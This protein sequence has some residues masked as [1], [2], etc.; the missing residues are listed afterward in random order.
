MAKKKTFPALFGLF[1]DGLLPEK[2]SIVGYARSKMTDDEFSKQ[3]SQA[4]KPKPKE[5]KFEETLK[6]FV[7]LCSYVQCNA[8]D[9]VEDMAKLAEHINKNIEKCSIILF[10]FLLIPVAIDGGNRLFYLALPP[11]VFVA[12]GTAIKKAGFGKV[13]FGYFWRI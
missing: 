6:A 13:E 1:R 8:Y 10:S 4:A 7:A 5:E 12:V 2:L 9:S 11:S 3:V